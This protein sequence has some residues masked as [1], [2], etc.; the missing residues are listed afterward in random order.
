MNTLHH[1]HSIFTA[2][3]VFD[4]AMTV[5]F[6]PSFLR[7]LPEL[8]KT[9]ICASRRKRNFFSLNNCCLLSDFQIFTPLQV[10]L[11]DFLWYIGSSLD[12]TYLLTHPTICIGQ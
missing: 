11:D 12:V 10:F 5:T 1:Y 3:L 7:G 4:F 6:V 8:C 2:L 9:G